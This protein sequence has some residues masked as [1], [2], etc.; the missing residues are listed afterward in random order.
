MVCRGN[1]RNQPGVAV[2]D[3]PGARPSSARRWTMGTLTDHP[4]LTWLAIAL[5]LAA[6]EM[7]TLDFFF[8]M[9]AVAAL[10]ASI[11]GFLGGSVVVQVVVFV[12]VSVAG[13]VLLRPI[14]IRHLRNTPD[15]LT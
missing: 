1:R 12:L 14:L 6:I 2:D 11:S 10:G 13:L 3:G 5:V 7:A 9:L 8:L 4:G 15:T